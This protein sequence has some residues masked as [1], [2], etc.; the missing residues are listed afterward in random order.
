[1]DGP[2]NYPERGK[3][4]DSDED[5]EENDGGQGTFFR[6]HHLD[7]DAVLKDSNSEAEDVMW[8]CDGA[9][10]GR[11]WILSA[12]HCYHPGLRM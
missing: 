4:F 2:L 12:A 1:M 10:I 5:S 11:R 6:V 8:K 7:S 3:R 9:L